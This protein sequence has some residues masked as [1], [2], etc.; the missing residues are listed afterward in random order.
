MRL[1]LD[2]HVWL[3]SLL[4]PTR[5]TA[6]VRRAL[7]KADNELWLSPVSTWEFALLV[8]RGRIEIA[9]DLDTWLA[10]ANERAP[11]REAPLTH[12]IALRSRTLDLPHG[13]PADRFIAATAAVMGLTLVT[14]DRRIL[15]SKQLTLMANRQGR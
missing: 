12:E 9:Q 1:L 3:W 10:M 11:M 6:R 8:E 14:A 5:L 7:S 2:T 13:D 4:D 15:A